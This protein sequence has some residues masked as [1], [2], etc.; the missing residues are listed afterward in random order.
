MEIEVENLI[1]SYIKEGRNIRILKEINFEIK[2]EEWLGIVGESG[3]GKTTL[4]LTILKLLPENGYI[5]EGRILYNGENLLEL[6][7]KELQSLRGKEIFLINQEPHLYF[8]PL[9]RILPQ[10]IEFAFSHGLK[11]RDEVRERIL[12]YIEIVGLEES[13]KWLNFFPFQLSSGM[14]QRICISMALLIKPQLILA[15]E[16]TSF[17]D[18]VNEK[19]VLNLLK[20]LRNFGEFSLIIVTHKIESLKGLTEITGVLYNGFLVE[21]GKTND[22]FSEP[23]HPY[24]SFLLKKIGIKTFSSLKDESKCPFIFNCPY[25]FYKC[26][27]LPPYAKLNGRRVRCWIY[28]N[29]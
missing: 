22:I 7:E 23:L 9:R 26:E 13:E 15:D 27:K 1:V 14:L 2:K 24:T 6:S 19:Q 18:S 5:E 10:I 29:E 21:F 25:K 3:S 16:P 20:K 4:L 28:I 8:N 12:K 17:L 11:K